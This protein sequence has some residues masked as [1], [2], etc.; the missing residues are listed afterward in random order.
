MSTTAVQ[1]RRRRLIKPWHRRLAAGWMT[2]GVA[3][4]QSAM[5]VTLAVTPGWDPP[6]AK[7]FEIIWA[8]AHKP[9]FYPVAAL[10][11]LGPILTFLACQV[12]GMHRWWLVI[13]WSAFFI[14]TANCF[15]DRVMVMG[16]MLWW[17]YVE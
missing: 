15:G 9:S 12:R 14:I 2:W 6:R 11:V 1:P 17:K 4:L 5:L 3:L 8:W 7:F 13:C 10:L 16:R